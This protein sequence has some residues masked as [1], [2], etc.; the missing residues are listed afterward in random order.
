M[1]LSV[2]DSGFNYMLSK[3]VEENSIFLSKSEEIMR[4]SNRTHKVIIDMQSSFRGYLLTDDTT[5][6][7]AYYAGT[8]S[9]PAYLQQQREL[10]R[11]DRKQR[12]LLDS[13]SA[14]HMRWV[15]Y[16]GKLIET[17]RSGAASYNELFDKT[18]RKQVGKKMNDDITRKFAQFDRLE[19]ATRKQHRAMLLESIHNTH[20]FSL[21]FLTLT[22]VIGLFSTIYIMI[23][24]TS[25]IDYMVKLA[26]G[27]A[28]GQFAVVR[29]TRRDE[30]TGLSI[31]LNKMSR[32]LDQTIRELQSR[33]TELNKFAYVVS[34]D[35]K[36][37]LRGIHNVITWIEEDLANEI[38]PKV[39]EYL[40]IIRERS[41]RMEALIKGLL[42]YARVNHKTVPELV[43][44]AGL[45]REIADSLVP[46]TFE[47][48]I[49]Q[50]PEIHTE[51][52]KLEQ[53][54]A[55]LISNAVKYTPSTHGSISITCK[56][57][58]AHYEFSV[59]DNGV[60]ID[61]AYH[62]KIFEIFQTLREK[63]S[64]E[65]TGIGLAIIKKIIDEHQEQIRIES[66]LGSG[67]AFIF[68]WKK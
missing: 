60:G 55:N 7:D 1:L 38:S 11:N 35:L 61:P 49:D 41:L 25:R 39:N 45:V 53:I 54:F 43:D 26:E 37:P 47:L 22:I 33:N 63:N 5:F 48:Q 59:K 29:D 64:K 67:S 18:L 46:R 28:Q 31:S 44:T 21:I 51:R 30:L 57:F 58:P 20:M 19:Y 14:V 13:I 15:N 2:A 10:V 9:V 32:N 50:L 40:K 6:L 24:I 16:S 62:E 52:L 68:T 12:N 23:L 65:S 66:V 17:R 3:K 56:E 4:N 34:H 42:D 36:A 8:E 27:I